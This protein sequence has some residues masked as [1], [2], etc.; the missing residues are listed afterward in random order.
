M[1]GLGG[2]SGLGGVYGGYIQAEGDEAT[3]RKKKYDIDQQQAADMA[4]G[5][6]LQLLGGGQGQ[7]QGG[8]QPP[9]GGPPPGMPPQGQ[10]PMQGPPPGQPPQGM[11]PPQGQPMR[12]PMPP[13]QMQQPGQPPMGGPPGGG[14]Q[15]PMQRSQM[16]PQQPPQGMPP[17]GAQ[18]QQGPAL[19]WRQV[20]QKVQQANP[21]APP[22]V[23]AA[24]VDRFLPL[25]NQQSQ[26]EWKQQSMLLQQERLGAM[27]DRLGMEQERINTQRQ[28]LG[29]PPLGAEGI[30]QTEAGAPKSK[31]SGPEAIG[32]AII[33][34]KQPP[35]MTGLYRQAPAVRAYL[36]E[37]DFNMAKAMQDWQAQTRLTQT[38]NGPQQVKFRQLE[39]S[40]EPFLAEIGDLSEQLDQGGM[41][42]WNEAKLKAESELRGNSPTG[43]LATR[44]LTAFGAIKG[45]VA[46]LE[47]GGY[48]PTDASWQAAYDQLNSARGVKAQLAAIEEIK[49]IIGYRIQGMDSVGGNIPGQDNPY[50]KKQPGVSATGE[51]TNK[52]GWS[53]DSGATPTG[54]Q[55]VDRAAAKK[56]GY[57][58]KEIDEFEKGQ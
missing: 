41:T 51:P 12:P 39:K 15:P 6:T 44:Y 26:M 36:A 4:F 7:Q 27:S 28:A 54:P 47:N 43:Q 58:D 18:G 16:P 40:V 22:N 48:A 50:S 30:S 37:H 56:A 23:L 2:L 14:M 5:R 10:P 52:K 49:K 17:G 13:P 55:K 21:G 1:P 20:F 31:L 8:M 45:E 42:L 25:M 11:P 3:A 19:D 29:L 46:Q 34:Y 33:D 32:Q 35:V 24:A 57:T 9:M 38:M 53:D